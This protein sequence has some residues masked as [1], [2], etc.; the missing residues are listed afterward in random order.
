MITLDDFSDQARLSGETLLYLTIQ[1][2][3]YITQECPWTRK[4]FF[5][6]S[7]ALGKI[8]GLIKHKQL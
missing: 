7:S 1:I 2:F 4:I 5:S 8:W 3:I 6:C